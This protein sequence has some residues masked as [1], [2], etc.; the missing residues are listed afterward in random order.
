MTPAAAN[1]W[2]KILRDLATVALASFILVHET[3][4]ARSP[5][6]ELIGAGLTLLGIPPALRAD[7]MRRKRNAEDDE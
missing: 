5:N 6:W 1:E 3:V 4:A 2:I 7:E